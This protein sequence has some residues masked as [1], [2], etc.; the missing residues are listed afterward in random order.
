LREILEEALEFWN[1]KRRV[2]THKPE[3]GN[4]WRISQ[5]RQNHTSE[6]EGK[7]YR[8]WRS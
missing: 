5:W 4:G 3:D 8:S 7:R 6:E 1:W 2:F